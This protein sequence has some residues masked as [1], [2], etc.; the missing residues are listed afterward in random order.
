VFFGASDE[1]LAES[2]AEWTS[3]RRI[4]QI[5][6]T[7]RQ[8]EEI[9]A[10]FNALQAELEAVI[11]DRIKDTQA[12]LLETFDEDVH[13]TSQASGWMRRTLGSTDW[14]AGFGALLAT[15]SATERALMRTHTH[16]L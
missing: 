15:L 6:D 13:R 9:E 14:D 5:Y 7:C 4:L 11:A 3:R 12:S 16:L 10:A 1:V 8:H 2:K